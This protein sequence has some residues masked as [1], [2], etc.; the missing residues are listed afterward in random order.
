MKTLIQF[1]LFVAL[2]T[3]VF[4]ENI[5]FKGAISNIPSGTATHIYLFA[6]TIEEIIVRG[7]AVAGVE[8]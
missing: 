3:S 4:A 8:V 5:T 7:R 1:L 6:Q 2:N